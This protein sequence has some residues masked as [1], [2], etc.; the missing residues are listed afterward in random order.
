[1]NCKAML[2]LNIL[3][4]DT[5][6]EL[7]LTVSNMDG[8]QSEVIQEVQTSNI[9][10]LPV[11]ANLHVTL[12]TQHSLNVAWYQPKSQFVITQFTVKYSQTSNLETEQF[13]TR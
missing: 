9:A 6:Y 3:D 12:R 2:T 11:P 7:L 5:T 13:L 8:S 1:M 10:I 4:K